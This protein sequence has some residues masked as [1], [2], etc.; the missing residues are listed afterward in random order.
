LADV[1]LQHLLIKVLRRPLESAHCPA[2]RFAVLTRIEIPLVLLEHVSILE[3]EDARGS[4]ADEQRRGSD[5]DGGKSDPIPAAV[6]CLLLAG[7]A[8]IG[9]LEET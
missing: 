6:V 1:P 8:T 9:T 4:G 5:D 7:I 3:E 2:I